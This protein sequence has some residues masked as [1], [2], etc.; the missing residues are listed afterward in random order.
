[1]PIASH[2]S[3]TRLRRDEQTGVW[4]CGQVAFSPDGEWLSIGDQQ[5]VLDHRSAALLQGLVG[6]GG[7]VVS[8]DELMARAW[9]GRVVHE[10]SIAKAI[11]KLR[12]LLA[13]SG[14]VI[15][16]VHGIGYRLECAEMQP[17]P[18][19]EPTPA[20]TPAASDA[21]ADDTAPASRRTSRRNMLL[22]A[23]LAVV[24]GLFGWA[25]LE[26]S[27]GGLFHVPVRSAPPLTNDPRNAIGT[28]LWVDDNPQNN[29]LDVQYLRSRRVAV[30]LAPSSAEADHLLAINHYDLVISD[31]GRGEDR[32]AGIKFARDARA[33]G[34]TMPFMIYTM[35]PPDLARQRAQRE[36]VAASGATH[37]ALTPQEVRAK[38]LDIVSPRN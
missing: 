15:V 11:S 23:A 26:W 14:L 19:H 20:P 13:G 8:K 2:G 30:H 33:R 36:L 4:K 38:V 7:R 21:L 6:A 5:T 29:A 24:V 10:N 32:L 17:A 22:A 1:M 12:V 34:F 37:L 3:R 35:R 31:L 25:A 27:R 28:V 18:E 9:S 16:T